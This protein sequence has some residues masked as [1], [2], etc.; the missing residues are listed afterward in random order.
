MMKY[1]SILSLGLIASALAVPPVFDA[2]VAIQANGAPINVGYGGNASPFM[3]DWNGDGKQDLLL[4]QFDA[5]KIRF[6]ANSGTNYN[7]AFGNFA[8][9]QA[10]GSDISLSCG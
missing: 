7:P 5:G 9:L 4:G 8:Y 10:D 6:Y 3:V 2:P 1:Y